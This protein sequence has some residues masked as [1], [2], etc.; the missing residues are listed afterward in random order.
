M[1][2][3]FFCCISGCA[4]ICESF[5]ASL[6]EMINGAINNGTPLSAQHTFIIFS[7]FEALPPL[8]LSFVGGGGDFDF[9]ISCLVYPGLVKSL[10]NFATCSVM[11]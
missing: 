8:V 5:V 6:C 3:I 11:V 1:L 4:S 10:H 7:F 2:L 9:G